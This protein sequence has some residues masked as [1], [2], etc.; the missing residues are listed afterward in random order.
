MS[1]ERKMENRQENG[2]ANVFGGSDVAEQLKLTGKRISEA[3]KAL[4]I[5]IREM[6][7]LHRITEE[8]YLRHE[9]GDVDSSFSFLLKTAER[10]GMDINALITG[11]SPRLSFY[12]LTRKVTG[13]K[14]ERRPDFEYFHQAAQMRNRMAEPLTGRKFEYR[15][16]SDFSVPVNVVFAVFIGTRCGNG[17]IFS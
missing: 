3:R 5:S 4:G 6:A 13:Q 2:P 12:T 7:I 17:K 8:E 16:I 1:N 11:E 15:L 10:F 9:N 14:V